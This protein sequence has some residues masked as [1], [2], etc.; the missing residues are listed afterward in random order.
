MK[1]RASG[2]E[3][4]P[5]LTR[6]LDTMGLSVRATL[7]SNANASSSALISSIT[8]CLVI[9]RLLAYDIVFMACLAL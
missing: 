3:V 9:T 8:H 2:T 6:S 5:L 4:T 7:I 1:L